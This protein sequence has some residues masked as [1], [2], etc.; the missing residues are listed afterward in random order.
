MIRPSGVLPLP[1]PSSTDL[2][3]SGIPGLSIMRQEGGLSLLLDR[4]FIVKVLPYCVV[5][6]Q[7]CWAAHVQTPGWPHGIPGLT[8]TRDAVE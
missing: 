7:H 3:Y 1:E 6:S 2:V 4:Y 8:N 5:A